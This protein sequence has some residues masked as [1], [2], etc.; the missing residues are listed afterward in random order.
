MRAMPMQVRASKSPKPGRGSSPKA[1]TFRVIGRTGAAGEFFALELE[2]PGDLHALIEQ[3]GDRHCRRTSATP[4]SRGRNAL[5]DSVR[6]ERGRC[7]VAPTAGLHFDRAMLSTTC[8]KAG[9]DLAWLTLHVGA[10]TFQPVRVHNIAEHRMHSTFRNARA[11]VAAIERTRAAAAASSPSARP[12]C[13]R[14][15][16]R[17]KAANWRAGT[18]EPTSSSR[19][20]TVPVVDRL[21]TNFHLPKSTLLMLVSAFCR[22]RHD[23]RRLRHAVAERYR[24]FSYGDAMLSWKKRPCNLNSSPP[25]GHR[26]GRLTLAHGVVETPVFMPVGTYGTVRR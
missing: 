17:R 11:T 12:A 3:T 6:A 24:F 14:S 22:H 9:V 10:G 1:F 2:G 13:A 8:R 23:P 26:R 21:I 25:T 7:R 15:N 4:P 19:R 20:A 5:P 16:R 18:A